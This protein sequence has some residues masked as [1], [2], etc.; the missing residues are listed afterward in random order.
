[1]GSVEG[2]YDWEYV[3]PQYVD[4]STNPLEDPDNPD[5]W[6]DAPSIGGIEEEYLD[7]DEDYNVCNGVDVME[8]ADDEDTEK[9][10]SSPAE[11]R[12]LTRSFASTPVNDKGLPEASDTKKTPAK[13]STPARTPRRTPARS[14]VASSPEL[15]KNNTEKQENTTATSE[16]VVTKNICTD[17]AQWRTKGKKEPSQTSKNNTKSQP[18]RIRKQPT[19]GAEETKSVQ[20]PELRGRSTSLK[21]SSSLRR[22]ADNTNLSNSLDGKSNNTL[23]RTN[24]MKRSTSQTLNNISGSSF[25]S[26]NNLKRNHSRGQSVGRANSS[27]RQTRQRLNSNSSDTKEDHTAP[28]SKMPKLTFPNTPTFMK[29]KPVTKVNGEQYKKAEEREL[30]T[31]A[32]MRNELAKKRKLAQE[33]YKKAMTGSA[34]QPVVA[35]KLPTKPQG[36]QFQT[37]SRIKSAHPMETRSESK[38]RDFVETLRSSTTTKTSPHQTMNQKSA[39][40]PKPFKL[41]DCKKRKIGSIE[42]LSKADT[43]QSM[44][45][46]VKAFHRQTPERFRS[47]GRIGS[48]DRGEEKRGRSKSPNK[49]TMPKTPQFETRGRTRSYHIISQQE[50]EEVE[51]QEMKKN[52]FKAHPVNERILTN[53]NTGVRKVP[54]KPLTHPEEFHLTAAERRAQDSSTEE[55][56]YEFHA[57]PAPKKI[58]EGPVGIKPA[59]V[60]A[61]TIPKSPAFALKNRVRITSEL[62]ESQN[63]PQKV[64][65]NPIP[66]A[67]VPFQPKLGHKSTVPEPFTF[68]ER[69]QCVKV[70]KE[71]KIKEILE[72]EKRAREFQA[73]GCP[74]QTFDTLPQKQTKL[75]TM[76]Q[77]F[78]FDNDSRGAKRA[79]EWSRKIEEELRQQRE[80][81]TFKAT[82]SDVLIKKPFIP[83]KSLKP[84]TD[85]NDFELNT[86]KRSKTREAYDQR[87]KAQEAEAEALKRQRE[88][89]Q[90]EQEKLAIAKLRAEM[91]PKSQP[92]KRF[93]TVEVLPSERPVTVPMSPKLSTDSRLRSSVRV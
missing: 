42:D 6:F 47:R 22:S 5:D 14:K 21:R 44:A 48:T 8:D 3:A 32:L 25:D 19:N 72:E 82:S 38:D 58:L 81:A 83:A 55:E 52:Q 17:L 88:R 77:P 41:T 60:L 34:N 76:P 67:G 54:S 89:R 71:E 87:R 23:K 16:P 61:R 29:R 51:V 35:T 2:D 68:E 93:K 4:F 45:E 75:P 80:Q 63:E 33:S 91:V 28:A 85:V 59:K 66:H 43:F 10:A 26:S 57:K 65:A 15:N 40:I 64:K 79:E 49:L 9:A 27:D 1:M 7:E 50:R 69:D 24:S 36:F 39:T 18:A 46:K 37:D 90:E 20:N 70:K 53:P 86:D 30:E 84:L 78:H 74:S 62:E 31:I 11:T 56:K 13:Q 92:V 12:R 73:Q